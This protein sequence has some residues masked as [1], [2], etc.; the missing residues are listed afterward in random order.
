MS[1][2]YTKCY[3]F[4][5]FNHSKLS[6]FTIILF[7]NNMKQIK[8]ILVFIFCI[9]ASVYVNSQRYDNT[10]VMGYDMNWG[11]PYGG[12]HLTFY[13]NKM[14]THYYSKNVYISESASSMSDPVTGDLLFYSNGCEIFDHKDQILKNGDSIN[15]TNIRSQ[16][17]PYGYTLQK[18]LT[19][20]PVFDKYYL[21]NYSYAD[22]EKKKGYV[23]K[24]WYSIIENENGKFVVK[25]KNGVLLDKKL[26]NTSLKILKHADGAS[27]WIYMYNY[28]SDT[29]F[30]FLLDQT[31]F[32]GPFLQYFPIPRGEEDWGA[33]SSVSPDG[34]IGV[35]MDLRSGLSIFDID[36]RSGEFSNLRYLPFWEPKDRINYIQVCGAVISPNSRFLYITLLTKI[37]QFDLSSND[38]KSSMVLLDTFDW[39]RNP[40]YSTFYHGQLA[41]D[42]K[43]YFSCTNGENVLHVIDF[44]NEKG[45]ACS[46]RQ[47]GIKLPAYNSFTM[48]YYPNYRLKALDDKT[49]SRDRIH[50]DIFPNPSSQNIYIDKPVY[51]TIKIYNIL[52]ALVYEGRDHT[53][54]I[55][56]YAN[57]I[58]IAYLPDYKLHK[59]FQKI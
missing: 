58:Y 29:S 50:F 17:C 39:S 43:I 21:I 20:L 6:V 59:K 52:G 10:W 54:D 46:F 34:K 33:S 45:K 23:D 48:P 55:S 28:A 4:I 2:Y 22:D 40:F 5:I 11:R 8:N 35:R 16:Y 12:I 26:F 15:L 38:L 9:S 57:G 47:H 36:R 37:L 27:W 31:G 1:F 25:K 32:K 42:G 56:N 51:S 53:L 30:R 41:P 18:S 44:P 19:F 13:E 3:F 14:D 49:P 7:L 24:L